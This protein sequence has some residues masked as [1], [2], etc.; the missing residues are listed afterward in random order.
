[1]RWFLLLLFTFPAQAE[2]RPGDLY[3]VSMPCYACPLI[4]K[5]TGSPYSHVAIVEEVGAHDTTLIM[6]VEPVVSRVSLRFIQQH[7]Q[8]RPQKFMRPRDFS[9][10]ALARLRGFLGVPFDSS[11][12]PGTDR[13]YCSELAHFVFLGRDGAPIFALR[14]M[15]FS[16][17]E[18]EWT[19]LLGHAPPEGELGISPGDLATSP[20][21]QEVRDDVRD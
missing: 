17:F 13:L 14:P 2:V 1:M 11:F 16:P 6:A 5:T 7:T 19:T 3:F 9:P 18:A 20:L 10:A 12:L 8:G 21:L 15:R 4:E